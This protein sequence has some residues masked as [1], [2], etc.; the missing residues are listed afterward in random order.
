[1]GTTP[2]ATIVAIDIG[3]KTIRVLLG[4]LDPDGSLALLG[5]AA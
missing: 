3:T 4:K 2:D 5:S 1:M